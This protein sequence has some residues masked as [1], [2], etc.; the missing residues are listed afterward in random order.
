[1]PECPRIHV[2]I[3]ASGLLAA[4]EQDGLHQRKDCVIGIGASVRGVRALGSHARQDQK[5]NGERTNPK[6]MRVKMRVGCVLARASMGRAFVSFLGVRISGSMK[7][8]R[9][10]LVLASLLC[11]HG[12][13][14]NWKKLQKL[15]MSICR[16]R[17]P[18]EGQ[19]LRFSLRYPLPSRGQPCFFWPLSNLREGNGVLAEI[20]RNPVPPSKFQ[21]SDRRIQMRKVIRPIR[22]SVKNR[23]TLHC[24]RK[25]ALV[26]KR[27]S[28]P[29]PGCSISW[30][31]ITRHKGRTA[32][33]S[34]SEAV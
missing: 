9:T 6:L 2:I 33:V 4:G 25:G 14:G 7:G 12:I 24:T 16:S 23:Q 30:E 10:R 19:E 32:P 27:H 11:N 29:A 5:L 31:R 18:L 15:R 34:S 28:P 17:Y 8:A 20:I 1:M 26:R 13:T 22:F 21:A 3:S